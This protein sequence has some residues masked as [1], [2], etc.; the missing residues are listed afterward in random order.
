[1]FTESFSYPEIIYLLHCY[2][3]WRG[4]ISRKYPIYL[5][6]AHKGNAKP[7]TFYVVSDNAISLFSLNVSFLTSKGI[8]FVQFVGGNKTC[9]ILGFDV[10]L[11]EFLDPI[12]QSH[13]IFAQASPADN[14]TQQRPLLLTLF[15]LQTRI[16]K[17]SYRLHS[18]WNYIICFTAPSRRFTYYPCIKTTLYQVLYSADT[19]FYARRDCY[20]SFLF[21]TQ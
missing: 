19:M 3:K 6:R 1:M 2:K 7:K 10:V 15:G 8:V 13:F 14:L 12:R 9:S 11:Q 18:P 17:G 21:G 4:R 16:N 20:Q 5:Q